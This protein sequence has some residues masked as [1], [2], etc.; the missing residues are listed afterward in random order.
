MVPTA[1]SSEEAQDVTHRSSPE[2]STLLSEQP[3]FCTEAC[4]QYVM[5]REKGYRFHS[6]TLEFRS[7][8]CKVEQVTFPL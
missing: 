1:R 3:G 2:V 8:L 7:G 4:L 5:V 6:K